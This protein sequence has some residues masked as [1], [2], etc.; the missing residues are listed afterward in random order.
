[1]FNP[2][3]GLPAALGRLQPFSTGCNRPIAVVQTDRNTAQAFLLPVADHFY[4]A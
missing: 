4:S 3:E 1:M 2:Y